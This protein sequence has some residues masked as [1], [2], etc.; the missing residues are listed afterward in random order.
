MVKSILKLLKLK[1][2][3]KNIVIFIPLIF[4]LKFYDL[5]SDISA[6]I[7]FV[8]FSFAASA[9]YVLNDIIDIE[10]DRVHPIKKN[11]PIA[12]GIISKALA[13]KIFIVLVF[14]SL[15][16]SLTLNFYAALTV[17][18]YLILNIW[19]SLQLKFIPIIDVVCIAL[20]FILRVLCGC[21]AILAVPSPLVIL[22]TFF[23]SMF[24]TFSKR[25]LEYQMINE[26]GIC[27][28]SI[29][30][31]NEP[32]LNQYVSVNAILSIAFYFTYMLDQTTINKTG[33][34]FLYITVI[35]FSIIIFR[36]LF[37]IYTCTNN[38]DPADFIYKDKTLGYLFLIYF[39]TLLGVILL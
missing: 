19:Y 34:P 36:L 6:I 10:N 17:V 25:K 1:H 7:A 24:F 29:T 5:N 18:C 27:R 20:G 14:I 8:V 23:T 37:K 33:A 31:Y 26:K 16:L 35:P 38:D 11:R 22:L 13:W 30:Q 3:I 21:A 4:S 9:I 15:L 12:S 28:K 39:I 32:L 2:H